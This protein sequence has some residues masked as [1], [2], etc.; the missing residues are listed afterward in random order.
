MFRFPQLGRGEGRDRNPNPHVRYL[1]PRLRDEFLALCWG[2]IENDHVLS[3]L[4]FIIAKMKNGSQQGPR[5]GIQLLPELAAISALGF[6]DWACRASGSGGLGGGGFGAS[7][8]LG[9]TGSLFSSTEIIHE[10]IIYIYI[11]IYPNN[12]IREIQQHP[13]AVS[14]PAA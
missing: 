8:I 12:I 9:P 1:L 3:L 2:Y 4:G 5:K 6:R 11:Y 13:D 7:C 14:Q 10:F